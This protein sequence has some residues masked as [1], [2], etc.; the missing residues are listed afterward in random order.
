MMQSTAF[1]F[2]RSRKKG[3]REKKG[4]KAARYKFLRGKLLLSY[5]FADHKERKG[6]K[7]R[8]GALYS[9]LKRATSF[10]APGRGKKGKGGKKERVTAHASVP[11]GKEAARGGKRRKDLLKAVA[12]A[13]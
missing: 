10:P 4:G 8:G 11:L 12:S 7:G 2:S 1:P 9:G 13:F 3:K 5:T 6:K